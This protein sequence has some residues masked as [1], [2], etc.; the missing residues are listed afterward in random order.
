MLSLAK[1][2]TWKLVETPPV[3]KIIGCRWIFKEKLG[4]PWVE[5]ARYIARM[6]AKGFSQVESID[7]HDIFSLVVKHSSI[8]LLLSWVAMFDLELEQLDEKIAFFAW[9]SRRTDLHG[10]TTRL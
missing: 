2:N 9:K 7:Y 5:A 6:V 4:I 10:T 8:R 3:K 1:N